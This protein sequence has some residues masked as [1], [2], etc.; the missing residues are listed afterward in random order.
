MRVHLY[1]GIAIETNKWV[2]GQGLF[3]HDDKEKTISLFLDDKHYWLNVI[4]ETVK[5]WTGLTDC[6]GNRIFEGDIV[7]R[8]WIDIN[9]TKREC[10][11]EF[12]IT[13]EEGCFM[14]RK[15]DPL[16][17]SGL[18]NAYPFYSEY[19]HFE[20]LAEEYPEGKIRFE[21]IGNIID[22]PDFISKRRIL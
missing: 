18:G 8:S 5:E 20:K 4:P 7:R 22:N 16:Y 14:Y 6:N 3:V 2:F 19:R 9:C 21:V 11:E 1:K 15:P 17:K 13:F 12:I 10:S